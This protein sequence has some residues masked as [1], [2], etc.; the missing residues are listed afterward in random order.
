M[1]LVGYQQPTCLCV[2][3][4]SV[5]GIISL[6]CELYSLSLSC[7]RSRGSST[8]V[9]GKWCFNLLVDCCGSCMVSTVGV[10]AGKFWGCEGFLPEFSQTC[11][12]SFGR[13]CLQIFPSK[14]KKPFF[15]MT[16]KNGLHVFFC[17]RWA[18][19]YEIK[20]GWAPFLPVFSIHQNF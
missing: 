3:M 19:F 1:K 4:E 12:K 2:K 14:I 7:F 5:A 11:P 15:G 9:Y 17:K 13:L 18:P 6:S 16:S 8:V 20:Q 10:G